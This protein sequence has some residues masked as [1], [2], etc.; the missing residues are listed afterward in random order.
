MS[1]PG[2]ERKG[3]GTKRTSFIMFSF[4][5]QN[6]TH[7]FNVFFE[8]LIRRSPTPKYK[9]DLRASKNFLRKC[10]ENSPEQTKRRLKCSAG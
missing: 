8:D 2:R 6:K 3:H 9:A 5:K 4:L 7:D 1:G 10:W